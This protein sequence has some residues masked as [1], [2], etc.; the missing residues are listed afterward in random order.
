MCGITGIY[1]FNEVGRINLINLF[2]ATETLQR[3]GPDHGALFN[4]Y[5]VGLGHRRLS[6]IDTSAK[7]N[8]PMKDA[9]GRYVIIYNGEIY[10]YKELRSQLQSRGVSFNSE[11]DTEVLLQMFINEGVECLKK[12]NG[13]FAF[14]IYDTATRELF[15]ARD[16]IGIKPFYYFFDEDRFLFASEMRSLLTYGI[17]VDIDHASLFQYLELNY[18]PGPHSI[19]K[20]IKKLPP[21]HY[22]KIKNNNLSQHRYCEMRLS[23]SS[24]SGKDYLGQQNELKVLLEEAVEK[25]LVSDVPLGAF[26]SGGIDSSIIVALAS[27]FKP[28]LYTFSIGYKGKR[29]FDETKYAE[30]VARHF[31]TDH[32]SFS[33]SEHDLYEHLHQVLDHIDEPFADS[34]A[35]PVYILSK[36]TRREV[37]VALSGDGADELFA[38]YNKHSAVLRAMQG[39]WKAQLVSGLQPLWE[40]LPKSRNT[41]FANKIRQ[42]QRFSKITGLDERGRYWRLAT[43][44]NEN[45][46]TRLLSKRLNDKHREEYN[47]RKDRILKY[48][49]SD[50]DFNHFLLTDVELVLV[51]DMLKKVDL[52]SMAHGLEVRVP[53][54][55]HKVVEYAFTL[56]VGSKMNLKM[57]KRIL[58]DAFQKILPSKLYRRKKH[59]FEVPLLDW[60]RTDLKGLIE[61]DLL[62]EE[63]ITA[64]GLFNRDEIVRIRKKLFSSNPGDVHA[65]IWALI[66]F[67]HWWKKYFSIAE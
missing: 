48:L 54:L 42:L 32:T 44:S 67:Q 3:R 24:I 66:V 29:F 20:K 8:Q 35:L 65:R 55:D 57:Q 36:F 47:T 17:D 56:P 61:K 9:T 64:Q 39:G 34:S 49:H 6:V 51:E 7:A 16:R 43:V 27:K 63:F 2:K 46:V 5:Y 50:G 14:S 62:N 25:R 58:R 1:A 10:N 52:M 45:E 11:S 33:L 18:I 22:M 4:D 28:N 13:F 59:G 40:I 30:L 12:L 60:L 41:P 31:K 19:F 26:L 38:G 23:Q 37:K 53:F 15:M 21:G